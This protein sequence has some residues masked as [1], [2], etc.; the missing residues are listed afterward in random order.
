MAVLSGDGGGP[1]LH[2]VRKVSTRLYLDIITPSLMF[3]MAMARIAAISMVA[4]GRP[5]SGTP[6]VGGSV[7]ICQ[8]AL[9]RQWEERQTTLPAELIYI[10]SAG[11]PMPIPR[12]LMAI[13]PEELDGPRREVERAEEA[14]KQAEAG[15]AD[16]RT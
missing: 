5:V 9:E 13:S 2:A 12:D 1:A 6:A 14:I 16:D 7:P 4:A 15:H 8:P 10:S 3:G 11:V